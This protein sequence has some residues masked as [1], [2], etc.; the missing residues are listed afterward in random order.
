MTGWISR[1]FSRSVAKGQIRKSPGFGPARD[2]TAPEQSELAAMNNR[3]EAPRLSW[4]ARDAG[5]IDSRADARRTLATTSGFAHDVHEAPTG[6]V[7]TVNAEFVD[8]VTSQG[9]R[10]ARSELSR[11]IGDNPLDHAVEL[12]AHETRLVAPAPTA[13][14]DPVVGWLVIINGP[15]KGQSLEIGIGANSIGRLPKEKLRMYFGDSQISRERH[16]VVTY[17]PKS[18]RFFL[19]N[20]EPA[21]RTFVNGK[22]VDTPIEL[23]GG[24]TI[25]FGA[26]EVRFVRFCSPGF[27]WPE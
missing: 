13:C 6:L 23:E 21:N 3:S 1:L 19:Q 12:H 5:N 9:K 17:D 27:S 10:H 4:P 16:A 2:D 8:N 25:A 20:G 18:H 14:S 24:E 22:V 11:H 7:G 26:T 15:G